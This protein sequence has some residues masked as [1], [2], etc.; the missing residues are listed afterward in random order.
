M[1]AVYA[2][3]RPRATPSPSI[4]RA[5]LLP[6]A[7]EIMDALAIQAAEAA[8]TPGYPPRRRRCCIVELEG[9]REDV[10][11]RVATSRR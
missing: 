1:L 5:G 6:V 9:E 11:A 8:V 10:D 7:M 2:R 3:S 4:V